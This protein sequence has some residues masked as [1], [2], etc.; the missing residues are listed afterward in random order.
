MTFSWDLPTGVTG[1]FED[2]V[3]DGGQVSESM[4]GDGSYTLTNLNIEKLYVT[5]EYT[6]NTPPTAEADTY[7]TTEG[8]TLSIKA[9]G[10]LK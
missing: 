8:E 5:L 9:P 4:E 6:Q 1:T 7:S 10:V 3:T 2:V